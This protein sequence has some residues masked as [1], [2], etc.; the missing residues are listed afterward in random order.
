MPLQGL[1]MREDVFSR[2]PGSRGRNIGL[3]SFNW[4]P[5]GGNPFTAM[6]PLTAEMVLYGDSLTVFQERPYDSLLVPGAGTGVQTELKIVVGWS[7]PNDGGG[8]M[9]ANLVRA[10]NEARTTLFCTA[11]GQ[12]FDFR[13]DGSFNLTLS[14]KAR[15]SSALKSVDLLDVRTRK[16]KDRE[17]QRRIHRGLFDKFNKHVAQSVKNEKYAVP[18]MPD[19][20]SSGFG[21]FEADDKRAYYM[22]VD[23]S[24]AK[25]I[26]KMAEMRAENGEKTALTYRQRLERHKSRLKR[27]QTEFRKYRKAKQDWE[28]AAGA[29]AY[30]RQTATWE[31]LGYNDVAIEDFVKSMGGSK[32]QQRKAKAALKEEMAKTKNPFSMIKDS[33]GNVI[34]NG[35]KVDGIAQDIVSNLAEQRTSNAFQ[36]FVNIIED[37]HGKK[38]SILNIIVNKDEIDRYFDLYGGSK[39]G[40][41]FE[42]DVRTAAEAVLP[43]EKKKL[44]E[45]GKTSQKGKGPEKT[46]DK[47]PPPEPT[48]VVQ[49]SSALFTLKDLVTAEDAADGSRVIP[50]FYF[51]DLVDAIM[52][53]VAP[54]IAGERIRIVL[55][56]MRYFNYFTKKAAIVPLAN[57]PISVRRYNAWIHNT[58][59]KT[60]KKITLEEFLAKAVKTLIAPAFGAE[61]FSNLP[62]LG[63]DSPNRCTFSFVGGPASSNKKLSPGIKNVETIIGALHNPGYEGSSMNFILVTSDMT[64]QGHSGGNIAV[65][66]SRGIPHIYLGANSG[67]IKSATF[68]K[69]TLTGYREDRMIQGSKSGLSAV[70]EPYNVDITTVGNTI[71][72]PGVQ[73]FLLPTLPGSTGLQVA[74]QVGLGGYFTVLSTDNTIMPGKFETIVKAQ[75]ESFADGTGRAKS[76][77]TKTTN[78]KPKT[79]KNLSDDTPDAKKGQKAEQVAKSATDSTTNMS[80]E[81]VTDGSSKPI[82]SMP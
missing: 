13:D 48:N 17:A 8:I 45:K 9:P 43:E 24:D 59:V 12:K 46:P 71:F 55:G 30:N 25:E 4:S 49:V 15:I 42:R 34:P 75:F 40:G 20:V 16:V 74:Q 19:E 11:V 21:K 53:L 80:I 72:K 61:A 3:K 68:S 82:A 35:D 51:G 22:A 31:S 60:I 27:D 77:R 65:D 79:V 1:W 23:M 81:P 56:S 76:S 33:N 6:S 5:A 52:K 7:V 78:T 47:G 69:V 62:P 18:L 38:S 58:F 73:F 28:K 29:A 63:K 50:F 14:Y 37:L 70:R 36:R 10:V 2:D 39:T 26:H 66:A 54:S 32:E 41:N 57:I 64:S 44:L 67:M